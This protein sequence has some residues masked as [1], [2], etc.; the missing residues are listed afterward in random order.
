MTD[1]DS[2]MTDSEINEI[3]S[4]ILRRKF[5]RLG[6]V[7]SKSQS[8]IDFDGASI[9]RVMAQFQRRPISTS[10]SPLDAIHEIRSELLERGEERFVFLNNEYLDEPRY[11]EEDVE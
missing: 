10:E 4:K 5:H 9:I 6:F 8:E 7:E 3:A 11:Q 1:S 2:N